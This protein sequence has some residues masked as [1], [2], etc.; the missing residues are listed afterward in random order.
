MEQR[1]IVIRLRV[2]KSELMNIR[3]NSIPFRSMSKYI[4][5]AL[6]EFSNEDYMKR[7]VAIRELAQLYRTN[8]SI[9]SHIGGN[10]NQAV[11]RINELA[12]MDQ[13][14]YDDLNDRIAPLI[15]DCK[16]TI[17]DLQ[18]KLRS[19]VLKYSL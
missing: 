13:L 14:H 12:K 4:R 5:T 1:D 7:K 9:I 8:S 16:S 6:K 17:D 10:L 11:H 15:Y 18:N 19:L 2:S 3:N